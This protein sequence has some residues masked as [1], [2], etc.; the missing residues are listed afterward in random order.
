MVVRLW[1]RIDA[2]RI[3]ARI[4]PLL[5]LMAWLL[6]P[7]VVAQDPAGGPDP[8]RIKMCRF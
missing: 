6:C 4:L 1:C 2:A 7:R 3:L 8:G 5:F